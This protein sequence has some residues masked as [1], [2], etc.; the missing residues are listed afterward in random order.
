V[1]CTCLLVEAPSGPSRRTSKHRTRAKRRDGDHSGFSLALSDDGTRWRQGRSP[2][3]ARMPESNG[4][5]ADNT[6][7]S[8]APC[9]CSLARASRWSQQAY[10]KSSSPNGADCQ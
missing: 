7:S 8:A 1:R 5:Q 2:K 10:I 4:N 3:T 9:T 6:A